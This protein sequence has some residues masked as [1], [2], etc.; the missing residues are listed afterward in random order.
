MTEFVEILLRRD[1]HTDLG[2]LPHGST[3]QAT[4]ADDGQWLVR[5][6]DSLEVLVPEAGIWAG[7]QKRLKLQTVREVHEEYDFAR[8]A[9]GF[10]HAAAVKWVQERYKVEERQMNRWGLYIDGP[11]EVAS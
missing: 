10:S 5:V 11:R 7:S 9:L 4:P 8:D 1:I 3:Q 2:I 6:T